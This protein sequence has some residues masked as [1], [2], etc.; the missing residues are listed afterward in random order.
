VRGAELIELHASADTA[1]L[2]LEP[3]FNLGGQAELVSGTLGP[4]AGNTRSRLLIRFD[5][6]AV[7]DGAAIQS[8]GLLC[9]VSKEPEDPV[10]SVFALHRMLKPWSEGRGGGSP[11]GGSL[12]QPGESTWN[13]RLSGSEAWADPGG[14]LGEDFAVTPSGS[15]RI[16]GVATYEIEIG[17]AGLQDL[18][19]WLAEPSTNYGWVLLSE[20]EDIPKTARRFTSR[21]AQ[22]NPPRLLVR[23]FAPPA[24]PRIADL[25]VTPDAVVLLFEAEADLAYV[26]EQSPSLAP[27]SWASVLEI[28]PSTIGGLTSVTNATKPGDL[29][30]IRLRVGL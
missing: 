14:F 2:E 12:A 15:E 3:D 10:E 5:L 7:P 26:W 11:P 24:S 17:A 27:G 8:A 6:S 29:G 21:E 25:D 18:E 19:D 20:S 1:L 9:T 13:E 30:F 4:A 23:Y 16:E 22:M 28:P